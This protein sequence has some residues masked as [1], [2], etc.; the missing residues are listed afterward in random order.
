MATKA[1]LEQAAKAFNK[2]LG[3]DP[4]IPFG[5]R[6]KMDAL[7]ADIKEAAQD[8]KP[9]DKFSKE[10]MKTVTEVIVS[11]KPQAKTKIDSDSKP[12]PK[13]KYTRFFS[14]C[15]ALS[16][17]DGDPDKKKCAEAAD[18]LYTKHTGAKDNLSESAWATNVVFQV[19]ASM[20]E[21]GLNA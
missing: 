10:V 15:E 12:A 19:I 9:G 21:Y 2:V 20:R 16:A 7:L 8:L 6:V 14:V 3:L 4:P 1:K 13:P 17:L 18:K 5:R 11:V